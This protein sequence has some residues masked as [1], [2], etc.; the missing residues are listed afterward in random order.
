MKRSSIACLFLAVLA[1]NAGKARAWDSPAPDVVLYTTPALQAPLRDL[2]ALYTAASHVEVHILVGSPD[3]QV[4]LIRHRAR[5][6]V[7]V[8][9]APAIDAL[10]AAHLIRPGTIVKLGT[11]GF[12]LISRADGALPAGATAAQLIAS[13]RV[14]LPDPT[15][16]GSF[17]G[18]G[19]L[20]ASVP[21]SRDARL[22]GVADTP[23]VLAL[24]HGDAGLLG[25]VN[26]TETA[27][28][29]ISE[30]AVL[31]GAGVAISG[32]LLSNGQSRNAAALLAFIAG[33]QGR[34]IL[35]RA[36]LAS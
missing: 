27:G 30:V 14:A 15:T 35:G 3:G 11:D 28:A 22:V 31:P 19:V 36:G 13:H 8:A 34:V 4:G 7:L 6:D 1:A 25:L 16:A 20:H 32:A 33:P 9:E 23:G 29:G 18:A 10:D 21:D 17:D 24:V 5:A 12:V 26:R 2:A